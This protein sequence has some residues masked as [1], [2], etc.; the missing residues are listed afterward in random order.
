MAK[1]INERELVLGILMEVT[2]KGQ[3]SHIVLREVLGKYQYLDKKER[4]F[5]TRVTEGTLEH[6]IE[7]DYILDRFSKVKVKKMKPVIRNI[8]RSAVYQLKYMDTVPDSAVCNEAVKL[9]VKKGFGGLR[10]C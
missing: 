1:P 10:G 5:I 8:L 9:A 2:E 7:L 4:A 6:M 3:Y